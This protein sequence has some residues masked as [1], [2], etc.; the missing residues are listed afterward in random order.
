MSRRAAGNFEINPK[1]AEPCGTAGCL[2]CGFVSPDGSD[3]PARARRGKGKHVRKWIVL[4][5]CPLLLVLALAAPAQAKKPFRSNI[6]TAEA[7]WISDVQLTPD[8]VRETTWYVGVF[9]ETDGGTFLYSDLYQDVEDCTT[10]PNGNVTCT[11]VSDKFGDS[12]LTGPGDT[13]TMDF[14]TLTS[15]HLQGTYTLQAFDQN[16]NPVGSPETDTIVADWTGTGDLIKTHSKFS[17]HSKCVHFT[18]TDKG[19][20]RPA[21]A[22]GT[23]NGTDLGTTS[24]TFFGGDATLQV[25]HFC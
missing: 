5:T 11:E 25:D 1:W 20:T 3:W 9:A 17:F 18:A 8:T 15:A 12:D 21:D 19:I 4:L 16:G 7:F 2:M 6:T 23:L 22:T 13:F 14:D 10:D 24:D